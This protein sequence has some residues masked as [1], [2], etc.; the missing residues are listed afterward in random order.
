MSDAS[1]KI[2]ILQVA[3]MAGLV[4]FLGGSAV[5][6]AIV[7]PRA[8]PST[9]H[10]EGFQLRSHVD[11]NFCIDVPAGSTQGRQLSL[12]V[13]SLNAT[14]RWT[15]T[16]NADGTNLIVDSMGMCV[17]AVGRKAGDGIAL[18]V[19]NCSFVKTQRFRYTSVG[20]IQLSGTTS[21]L[22]IPRAGAAA[23][24]FLENCNS[25][26]TRQQFKLSL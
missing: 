10:G 4:T 11:S 1:R 13:C 3:V 7:A 16:S 9:A 2:G 14:Q 22:S 8:T 23:A 6:A 20:R 18:K 15:F 5:A 26:T 19:V 24:V 21:C 12:G 25:A 17:D